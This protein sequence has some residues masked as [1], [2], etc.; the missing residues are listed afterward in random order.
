MQNSRPMQKIVSY[1]TLL[2]LALLTWPYRFA[3]KRWRKMKLHPIRNAILVC[4]LAVWYWNSISEYRLFNDPTCTVVEGVNGNL[5]GARIASDGQWRFPHNDSVPYKFQRAIIQFEDRDFETHYGFSLK[6]FA[7]AVKQ[8]LSAGRVVSGGST[9]TMQVVRLM[10]KG[11]RRSLYEKAVELILSTRIELSYS[12]EEILSYYA[13]NAPFGGNVVGLD[14]AAWRYFGRSPNQLSWAESATLAVL[15]NAPGLIYPG[16]NQ[17]ALLA[18][19][20]RLLD[21]LYEAKEIDSTTWVLAKYEPLPQKPYPIPQ[22]VPHLL[23]RLQYSGCGGRT[24][25]STVDGDLQKRVASIVERHHQQLQLNEIHNAAVLVIDVKNSHILAYVGNTEDPNREHGG[26]VDVIHAPRST[27]S[28]LKPFLYAGMLESGQ[29][30]PG[31]LVADVPTRISG[32]NPKNYHDHYDGAVPAHRALARSL[33]VPA[34]RMLREYGINKFHRQLRAQ[35]LTTL[36]K[37][38][39]H[40]GLSLVLGGAEASLYDLAAAYTTMA[41]TVNQFPDYADDLGK[42]PTCAPH[43]KSNPLGRASSDGGPDV[44]SPAACWY[45]FEAMKQVQRP[46]EDAQWQ[47]FNSSS[48]IAWKTGTSFGFRDAWAIG[49]TPEYVVAVWVGNADGEGRPGLV[50]V[51]AAAPL[52]FDVFDQLPATS[53]FEQP[54]DDCAAVPICKQSGHRANTICPDVEMKAIPKTA[55]ETVACPY[56]KSI[57]VD[58]KQEYRVDLECQDVNDIQKITWFVLPPMIETYYR[59]HHPNY[60]VLPPIRSDCNSGTDNL[61]MAVI[62]PKRL[63]RIYVPIEI[64]GEVGKTVFEVTHRDKTAHVYWHLDNAYLGETSGIHQMELAPGAGHH[65]LTLVDEQ[66]NSVSRSF[67]IIGKYGD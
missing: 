40:Y 4:V 65:Q 23:D 67:E 50:G 58:R 7:R 1:P 17:D 48:E 44:L 41:Q 47:Q 10:R 21:R 6:A 53:W 3:V 19:R 34:V 5:L 55:L 38:A 29:I 45:T 35:G 31:M 8:N 9:I 20:N 63:S 39:S 52:L 43:R 11:Q 25:K 18:K 61:T 26:G 62:Y 15:P 27:G 59:Q 12:K 51:K 42:R 36:N 14:A 16:R 22:E 54:F 60:K 33:N 49:V 28:I 56:H 13:S 64:D 2:L 32:Y 57:H 30:T 66:G 24:V 37:P 46:E